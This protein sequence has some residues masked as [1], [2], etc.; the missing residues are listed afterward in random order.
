MFKSN[1]VNPPFYKVTDE[2]T[3]GVVYMLGTIHVGLD[4]THYPRKIYKALDESDTLAV[5]LDLLRLDE[6]DREIMREMGVF[7]LTDQSA[8]DYMGK[9]YAEIKAAMEKYGVYSDV[10]EMYVPYIWTSQLLGKVTTECGYE[11]KYGTD[12]AMLTYAKEHSKNIY[13]IETVNQQYAVNAA[14]SKELQIYMLKD[15]LNDYDAQIESMRD[16]YKAWKNGD[17]KML[18]GLLD[19]S[20]TPDEIKDDYKEYYDNMYTHRQEKMADYVIGCLKNGEKSFVAVGALHYFAEPDII[21]YV[22][23]AGYTVQ[24]IGGK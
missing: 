7:V 10:L 24:Q 13:E 11:S 6:D 15:A 23:Q 16:L 4:Y 12:R 1:R 17:S 18:G 19:E 14:A 8:Q 2:S 3:G 20:G 22:E 21:D 9:E 5:E